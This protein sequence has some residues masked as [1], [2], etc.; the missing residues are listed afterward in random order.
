MNNK[1]NKYT[2]KLQ[3]I[4]TLQKVYVIIDKI[5]RKQFTPT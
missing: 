4:Q 1:Q 3:F 5:Y 2:V